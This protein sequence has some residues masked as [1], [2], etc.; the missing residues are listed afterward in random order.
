MRIDTGVGKIRE[1]TTDRETRGWDM[2]LTR[3]NAILGD[4]IRFMSVDR[5]TVAFRRHYRRDLK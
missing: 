3:I 2:N 1:G 4:S 5:S